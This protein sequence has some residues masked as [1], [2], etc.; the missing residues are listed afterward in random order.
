MLLCVT[1]SISQFI[2]WK[3]RRKKKRND[4]RDESRYAKVRWKEETERDGEGG[5]WGVQERFRVRGFGRDGARDDTGGWDGETRHIHGGG[6]D[7]RTARMKF[8]FSFC[9]L[10]FSS[11]TSY[12]STT[13]VDN[14][15]A[16]KIGKKKH[17][18][19]RKEAGGFGRRIKL[20]FLFCSVCLFG[21]F[22]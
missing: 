20:A 9:E 1:V 10:R 13:W 5:V 3:Q 7:G 16:N 21:Y 11:L 18:Y 12:W 19:E 8:C 4:L 2:N 22:F 6:R 14:M 15:N 17:Q